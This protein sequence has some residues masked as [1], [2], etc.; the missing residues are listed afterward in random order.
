MRYSENELISEIK[1]RNRN[2]FEV[3][4]R[5]YSKP[6]YYLAYNILGGYGTKEDIEE[7][8]SDVFLEIW[9]KVSRFDADRGNVKT[10]ILM[11][12]KY[13]AL[14][15]K[16]ELSAAPADNIED[17]QLE[18]PGTPERQALA[19]ETQEKLVETIGTFSALDKELFVRRYYF[20][21][22]IHNLMGSLGLSRSAV[23]NR[24]HRSRKVIKEALSHE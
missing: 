2:A 14:A 8:V 18:D 4:V 12:T 23:D 9:Q 1:R 19:R 22:S 13:R 11:L 15:Y 7:C 3:L 17:Y 20:G 6:M 24:L 10:W 5:E 16:R 21:E